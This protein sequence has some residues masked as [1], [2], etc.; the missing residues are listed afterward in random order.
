M[1]T[2]LGLPFETR[3]IADP[4]VERELMDRGGVHRVPFLIDG[5]TALYDSEAILGYLAATYGNH[6]G[7]TLSPTLRLHR[8]T[9]ADV[10]ESCQ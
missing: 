10:C 3:N 1:L 8:D 7:V 4:V 2:M 9:D 6:E 5:D